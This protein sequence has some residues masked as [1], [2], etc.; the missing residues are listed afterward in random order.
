MFCIMMSEMLGNQYFLARNYAS[1]A[2]NLQNALNIEPLNKPVR[3][4][5]VICYS[6]VGEIQ[7]A[8]NIF[9]NLIVEDIDCIIKTDPIADDCPCPELVSH[10]GTILPYEENSTDLIIMLGMLWLYCNANKS[11]SFFKS[12]EKMKPEHERIKSISS[13]IGNRT[14]LINKLT[15]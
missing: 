4:K 2:K 3:K 7:K 9:Y 13:I 11:L 10:Y 8:L 15:H 1:A 12:A 6:Q 5:L 14:S